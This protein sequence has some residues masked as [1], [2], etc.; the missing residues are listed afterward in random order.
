[1]HYA[2]G[3]KLYLQFPWSE[4]SCYVGVATPVAP[5]RS[6][7][8]CRGFAFVEFVTKKE[9]KNAMNSVGGAHLYGRRLV[10]EW[11]Q[12]GDEDLEDIRAKTA[13]KFRGETVAEFDEL[14]ASSKRSKLK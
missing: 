4:L 3:H 5:L 11:A 12:Q 8:A 14:P 13:A 2:D 9:A 6:C 10:V 7:A 1:M